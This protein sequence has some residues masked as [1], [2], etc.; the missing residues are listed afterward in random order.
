MLYHLFENLQQIT[1]FSGAGLFQYI[2]FRAG[3]AVITSLIISMLFGD[4]L[5]QLLRKKQV[6]E[7]IR[8]LGLD[9]QVEKAGTPTM[10]G[11][12]ILGAIL[13]PTLLFAKLDNV[14]TCLLY[15][16]PSPRD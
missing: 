7:S 11:L 1:D 15:T 5:I 12:I 4:K 16:S 8:D 2:S 3:M 14:Y 10:G 13:I 9:G 6:G